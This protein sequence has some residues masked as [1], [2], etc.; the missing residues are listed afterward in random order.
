MRKV[1]PLVSCLFLMACASSDPSRYLNTPEATLCIDY[2]SLPSANINQ[3]AREQ[4]IRVRGINCS[5]YV[6]AAQ[7][8]A[9][10][11]ANLQNALMGLHRG[12]TYRQPI[13]TSTGYSRGIA[14]RI[15][16][17]MNLAM[18]KVCVYNCAGYA[19]SITIGSAQI[20]PLI[21]NR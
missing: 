14:C 21:I 5:Y 2:M 3:A 17:Q 4:A 15:D 11:N 18:S 19:E 12:T 16:R 20:C 8:R 13:S 6:G 10:A 1:M 9:A 7:S